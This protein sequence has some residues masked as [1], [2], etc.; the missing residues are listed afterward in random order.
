MRVEE[1]EY[2]TNQY[3]KSLDLRYEVM[4]KPL[5]FTREEMNQELDK[6]QEQEGIHLGAFEEDELVGIVIIEKQTEN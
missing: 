1:I 4:R 3:L 6:T 2:G 5:G